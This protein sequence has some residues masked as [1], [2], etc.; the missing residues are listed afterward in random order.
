MPLSCSDMQNVGD[1]PGVTSQALERA[2]RIDTRDV[3]AGPIIARV[4][5]HDPSLSK[6]APADAVACVHTMVGEA[7]VWHGDAATAPGP[8]TVAQA[9][10]AFGVSTTPVAGIC[11]GEFPGA[12]VLQY[13]S[14]D[15]PGW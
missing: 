11:F 12:T 13:P 8:T 1:Q 4:H 6:C 7:I 3:V 2:L 15:T 14:P 9:A 5:T 10:A